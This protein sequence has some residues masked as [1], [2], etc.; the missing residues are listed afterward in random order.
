[1]LI[2]PKRTNKI[3]KEV[4]LVEN[5][6]QQGGANF[7]RGPGGRILIT[8]ISALI[9]WGL[10]VVFISSDNSPLVLIVAGVCAFFGWRALNRIQPTMFVWMSWA[11]WV[12]YFLIKFFLSVAI[13]FV[14]APFILGKKLGYRIQDSIQ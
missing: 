13:G 7:F 1:M 12:A 14:I 4:L 8:A 10:M 3:I 11:G 6:N 9:I 5:N 2:L